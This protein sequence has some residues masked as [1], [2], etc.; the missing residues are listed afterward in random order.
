MEVE[1]SGLKF[2]LTAETFGV[3]LLKSQFEQWYLPRWA[4]SRAEN[5]RFAPQTKQ[6]LTSETPATAG[7]LTLLS[8]TPK[9]VFLPA[10]DFS[11]ILMPGSSQLRIKVVFLGRV[12]KAFCHFALVESTSP[13]LS[14]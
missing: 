3:G 14:S 1:K 12:L 13:Y 2:M 6:C 5:I 10:N 4:E 9:K 8:E 7:S 11:K